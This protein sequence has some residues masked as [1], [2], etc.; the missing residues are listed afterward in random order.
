MNK[1][2]ILICLLIIIFT[3]K[4]DKKE[5]SLIITFGLI[6]FLKNIKDKHKR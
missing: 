5:N 6:P 1:I 3:M 2:I 4:I